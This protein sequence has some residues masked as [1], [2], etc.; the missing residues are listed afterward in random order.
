MKK[1]PQLSPLATALLRAEADT[2]TCREVAGNEARKH[3]WD[4]I[5]RMRVSVNDE[6]VDQFAH[7][8]ECTVNAMIGLLNEWSMVLQTLR[9]VEEEGAAAWPAF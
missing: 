1:Q 3:I 4:S 9:R 2:L 6:T 5:Q 7:E 8:Q